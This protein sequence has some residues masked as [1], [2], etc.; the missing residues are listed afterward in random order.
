MSRKRTRGQAYEGTESAAAVEEEER[1]ARRQKT[2]EEFI[3]YATQLGTELSRIAESEM[4]NTPEAEE[5][6][7]TAESQIVAALNN[8]FQLAQEQAAERTRRRQEGEMAMMKEEEQRLNEELRQKFFKELGPLTKMMAEEMPHGEQVRIYGIILNAL[9]RQLRKPEF[10]SMPLQEP[11]H[12]ARIAE[13]VST[14]YTYASQQLAITLSNVYNAA[15]SVTRQTIS[16]VTVSAMLYNYQ[17]ETVRTLYEGIPYFG[18]LFGVMNHANNFLQ[19]VTNSTLT[20]TGIYYFLMNAGVPVNDALASVGEMARGV[21]SACTRKAAETG[22]YICEQSVPAL[23]AMQ[24]SAAEVVGTVVDRFGQLLRDDYTNLRIAFEGESQDTANSAI[25]E[26]SART[27]STRSS[28]ASAE[29]VEEL[30]EVPIANGGAGINQNI[31][32]VPTQ[33]VNQEFNAIV[34][35]NISNPIIATPIETA[36][37]AIPVADV[38]ARVDTEMSAVSDLSDDEGNFNWTTWLYGVSSTGGKRMRKSRRNM[39]LRKTRKVRRARKGKMTKKSKKRT[40]T[41]KKYR[42]K[43]R[44]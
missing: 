14:A 24:E 27:G 36:G 7:R 13:S 6:L 1:P 23:V 18:P 25:S 9:D 29:A 37:P 43:L 33:L 30:F 15:P 35:G 39:K 5:R 2:N 20:T 41:L 44:R 34:E 32:V 26:I 4:V 11:D 22:L 16:V 40:K 17:P 42:T 31:M 3:E 12:A 8:S 19:I 10:E 38:I 21:A 28:Q